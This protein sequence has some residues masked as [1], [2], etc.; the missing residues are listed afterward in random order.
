MAAAVESNAFDF[1]MRFISAGNLESTQDYFG[2]WGII[3][4]MPDEEGSGSD[5]PPPLVPVEGALLNGGSGKEG[6]TPLS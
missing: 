4:V 3:W 1:K 2:K 5:T 6:E